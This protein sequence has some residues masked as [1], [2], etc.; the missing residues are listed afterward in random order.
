MRALLPMARVRSRA[1]AARASSTTTQK[2][3]VRL[4]VE[5][6]RRRCTGA[7]S[8]PP[9]A[10]TTR[11]LERVERACSATLSGPR[12]RSRSST[13]RSRP[14][15][16]RPRARAPSSTCELDPD[17]PADEAAAIVFDRL[18][19]MIDDNLPGTLDD[20]D[21]EFLHDLRV[22]VRRTR[23]LQRQFKAHLPRAPAALPRRVQA[24]AAGHRRPA[25]PRRLPARLPRPA[26]L[27]AR[28]RCAPTWTRC[29][30]CSRPAARRR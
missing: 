28:R 15:A 30:A 20:V 14:P 10:A 2:T 8:P 24:P 3:V 26:G 1:L 22:A 17:E 18:L 7:S 13:R 5:H 4:T 11:D 21:S 27:A 16:A 23:S 25:R 29:A 9:S 19:E 6:A 12:R